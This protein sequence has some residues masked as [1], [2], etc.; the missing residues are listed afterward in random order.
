MAGQL[1]SRLSDFCQLSYWG[2]PP[3]LGLTELLLSLISGVPTFEVT[4]NFIHD[5]TTPAL[6]TAGKLGLVAMLFATVA[7]FGRWG[8]FLVVAIRHGSNLSSRVQYIVS[9][10]ASLFTIA[11]SILLLQFCHLNPLFTFCLF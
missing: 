6:T 10:A 4:S 5:V 3:I 7:A 1:L 8:P 9:L 2:L 11:A